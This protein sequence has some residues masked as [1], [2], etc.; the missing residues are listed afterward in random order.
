MIQGVGLLVGHRET[1]Q[2]LGLHALCQAGRHTHSHTRA[3]TYTCTWTHT[4]QT[5]TGTQRHMPYIETQ[6]PDLTF[7]QG[8]IDT[9]IYTDITYMHVHARAQ[10]LAL[11]S[12]AGEPQRA[13]GSSVC[14]LLW[15]TQDKCL[16]P[17]LLPSRHPAPSLSSQDW[18]A[19]KEQEANED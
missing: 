3:H 14:A 11:A 12:T 10:P 9:Q 7:T 18:Q 8:H 2:G 1:K 5:H 15:L 16:D 4:D 6:R 13:P 17:K 19:D